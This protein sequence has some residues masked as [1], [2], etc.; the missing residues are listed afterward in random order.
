[1][2]FTGEFRAR[3]LLCVDESASELPDS[4]IARSK[5]I[6]PRHHRFFRATPP[7]SLC[8]ESCD[9][10]KLRHDNDHRAKDEPTIGFPDCRGPEL[11]VRSW[12]EPRRVD[13]PAL[14]LPPIKGRHD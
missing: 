14:H 12:W 7:G 2:Q 3:H 1:M 5:R 11:D 6:L 13:A 8:E 10:E 4:S 9:E